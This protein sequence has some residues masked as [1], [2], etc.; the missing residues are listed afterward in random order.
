MIAGIGHMV[1][2]LERMQDN[3]D[4][5]L[6]VPCPHPDCPTMLA[7]SA[8]PISYERCTRHR[9]TDVHRQCIEI[10]VSEWQSWYAASLAAPLPF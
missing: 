1:R 3:G 10:L 8:D 7:V 9:W 2:L 6:S 4:G 5:T